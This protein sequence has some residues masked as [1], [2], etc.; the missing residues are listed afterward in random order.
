VIRSADILVLLA[1]LSL[2]DESWT[3]RSLAERLGVP[4]PK[5]QRALSR[6][7]EAGLYDRDRRQPVR[8]AAREFL[9]HGLKYLNPLTEGPIER[10]VPTAW[11]AA[12]LRGEIVA[13]DLP[14]VWPSPHGTHRGPAVRP[15]D[16]A[17]TELVGSWP[18]VAELAT[19]TD[20][21]AIGDAR[22]R[23]LAQEHL[24]SRLGDR[25]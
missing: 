19:L 23:A 9:V 22:T 21:L 1:L 7:A 18:E 5:V 12:P 24:L 11:A 13:D 10:G 6:L 14:P 16:P 17:L 25:P 8:R 20:A 4:H 3:V 2:G 15:L